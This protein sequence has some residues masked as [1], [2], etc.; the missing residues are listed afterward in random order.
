MGLT[1]GKI[2]NGSIS[3]TAPGSL[4]VAI[5]VR[6]AVLPP[7]G[8]SPG[9]LRSSNGLWLLDTN[10]NNAY[11]QGID[12]VTMFAGNGLTPLAGDI[13]VAG[14]WNGNG[15]TK[16]GLYRP[17]TGTW[18]LD[19]NGNGVFDGPV[20]DRQY[21]YGGVAGDIPVAGDWNG[22]GVSKIGIFRG[23]FEW[24][25]NV[26]GNGAFSG[27]TNDEVFAFGG[28]KGCPAGLPGIYSSEPVGSCDIP[29]VGDWNL[30]GTTKV[31]VVRATP[32]TSQPFLWIL[33]T[34]G[35]KT[36]LPSGGFG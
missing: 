8:S 16:I 25:L 26:S 31:G 19:Y 20:V 17:S 22:S 3:V 34:T 36:F 4:T 1:P 18:F 33:D 30:S 7:N 13:A 14:D 2:Y 35:A 10:A 23:G 27:G 29:V 24:L 6:V 5:P 12:K 21:Q 11:D 9:I 28:L 32:G 15:I